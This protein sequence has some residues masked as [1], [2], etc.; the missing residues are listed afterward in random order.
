M[1]IEQKREKPVSNRTDSS[2]SVDERQIKESRGGCR[3]PFLFPT[4]LG[5]SKGLCSQGNQDD[6][7][8]ND[9]ADDNDVDDDDHVDDDDDDVDDY[10]DGDVDHD[11]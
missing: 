7:D 1:P 10:A 8:D 3:G 4:Y 5:R 9:D 2:V 6:D 11:R